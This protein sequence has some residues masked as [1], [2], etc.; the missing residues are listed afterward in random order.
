MNEFTSWQSPRTRRE[1]P[2]VAPPP[3]SPSRSVR[4]GSPLWTPRTGR[5]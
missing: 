2:R 4:S 5:P 3:Q 1:P